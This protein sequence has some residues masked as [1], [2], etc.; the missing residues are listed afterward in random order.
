MDG[1]ALSQLE[2]DVLTACL[3][4]RLMTLEQLRALLV[5]AGRRRW[6]QEV[7]ARLAAGGLLDWVSDRSTPGRPRRVWFVTAAGRAVAQ[8]L[9]PPRSLVITAERAANTLQR[10]TLISNDVGIAFARHAAPLGHQC[11]PLDFDH[12]VAHHLGTGRAAHKVVA[13]LVLRC[14]L[15]DNDG[16]TLVTRFIEIDR[17]QYSPAILHRKIRSYARLLTAHPPA[18]PGAPAPRPVWAPAY[19]V[20]PKLLIVF[21]DQ[22]PEQLDRRIGVLIEMCRDDPALAPYLTALGVGC[23][24]LDQVLDPG[25]FAP[26]WRIP[27]GDEPVDL[28]LRP[29]PSP[30]VELGA[31]GRRS[32]R[33]RIGQRPAGG[34]QPRR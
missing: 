27:L 33:P 19:P 13:D 34:G 6:M 15:H 28:L 32:Q 16:D 22:R 7:T 31:G 3:H 17:A 11:G 14:W 4:H 1:R 26:I 25:P 29:A 30:V 8:P 20:F 21:A 24:R 10:H 23:A 12:E 2:L 18:R 5:P 9:V